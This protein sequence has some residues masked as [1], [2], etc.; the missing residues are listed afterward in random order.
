MPKKK[1]RIGLRLLTGR[2]EADIEKYSDNA[3]RVS[4]DEGNPAYCYRL[5]KHF[6]SINDKKCDANNIHETLEYIE[7]MYSIDSRVIK[8]AV[9]DNDCGVNMIVDCECNKCGEKNKN[10]IKF[11]NEFFR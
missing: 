2:D 8:E 4:T 3:Y 9:N 10:I 11:T 7:K 6:V 5:A 1:D